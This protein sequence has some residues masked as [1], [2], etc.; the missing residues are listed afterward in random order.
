MSKLPKIVLTFILCGVVAGVAFAASRWD[1]VIATLII[2]T[3]LIV[4]LIASVPDLVLTNSLS[5]LVFQSLKAVLSSAALVGLTGLW[6]ARG[7]TDFV[8]P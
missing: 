1:G 2:F 4:T 7:T 6:L 5:L 8:D 3:N